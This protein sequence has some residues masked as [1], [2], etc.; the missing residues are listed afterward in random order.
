MDGVYE[1]VR[2]IVIYLILNTIIMNLLEIV[3][4]KYVSILNR[5]DSFINCSISIL[6]ALKYE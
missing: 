2:N 5:Y 3:V 1:W 4:I 6:K